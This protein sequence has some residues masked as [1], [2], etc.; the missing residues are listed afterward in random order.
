[1]L[2]CH[3]SEMDRELL[4]L[5]LQLQKTKKKI[6]ILYTITQRHVYIRIHVNNLLLQI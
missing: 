5:A 2:M 3:I 4:T 1:M 6:T